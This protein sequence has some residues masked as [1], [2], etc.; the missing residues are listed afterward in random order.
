MAP[1]PQPDSCLV[2]RPLGLICLSLLLIP[3]AGASFCSPT[4]SPARAPPWFRQARRT[5]VLLVAA[6]GGRAGLGVTRWEVTTAPWP[7]L[8]SWNLL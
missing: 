8:C 3:A 4:L 7:C 2:G 1:C 6:G 5:R